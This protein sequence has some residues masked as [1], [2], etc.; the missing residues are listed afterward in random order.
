[1][2]ITAVHRLTTGETKLDKTSHPE[3]VSVPV[4][5]YCL[6]APPPGWEDWCAQCTPLLPTGLT[7]FLYNSVLRAQHCSLLAAR[8]HWWR[9]SSILAT[10]TTLFMS[11]LDKP[12][13]DWWKGLTDI[14]WKSLCVWLLTLQQQPWAQSLIPIPCSMFLASELDSGYLKQK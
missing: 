10:M 4:R 8:S 3:Q 1:M 7:P 14:H 2:V 9:D 6:S 11:P 5:S 12:Q 13:S